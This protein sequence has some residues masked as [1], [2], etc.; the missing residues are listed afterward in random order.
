M[1]DNK[2]KNGYYEG[3]RENQYEGWTQEE[4]DADLEKAFKENEKIKE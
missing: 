2:I 1:A 3:P 4:I